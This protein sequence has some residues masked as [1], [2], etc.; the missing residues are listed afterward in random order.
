MMG[1]YLETWVDGGIPFVLRQL[2]VMG[3]VRQGHT[4]THTGVLVASSMIP[5]VMYDLPYDLHHDRAVCL[6]LQSSSTK[7]Y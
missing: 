4:H 7:K 3:Q 1:V 6:D 2:R 5:M